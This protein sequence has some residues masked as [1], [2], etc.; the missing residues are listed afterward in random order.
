MLNETLPEIRRTE[1]LTEEIKMEIHEYRLEL[2]ELNG[3]TE[4][5]QKCLPLLEKENEQIEK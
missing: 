2:K 3:K 5:Y 4:E 1:M